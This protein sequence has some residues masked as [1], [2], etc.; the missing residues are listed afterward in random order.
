MWCVPAHQALYS[1][2]PGP[3]FDVPLLV[4][5]GTMTPEGEKASAWHPL[6]LHAPD[7]VHGLEMGMVK[8]PCLVMPL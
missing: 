5:S 1:D 6:C 4:V 7:G 2:A 3:G 8:S